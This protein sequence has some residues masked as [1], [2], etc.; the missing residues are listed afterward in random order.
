[1]SRLEKV[2]EKVRNDLFLFKGTREEYLA[3]CAKR[4]IDDLNRKYDE[5]FD[6]LFKLLDKEDLNNIDLRTLSVSIQNYSDTINELYHNLLRDI[7]HYKNNF[8]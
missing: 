3:V 4:R 2:V 8:T 1:M 5:D 6:K 7:N